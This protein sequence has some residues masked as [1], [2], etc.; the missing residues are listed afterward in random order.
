[1]GARKLALISLPP[2]GCMPFERLL[3]PSGTASSCVSSINREARGFNR[4]LLALSIRMQKRLSDARIVYLDIYAI[5]MDA[6]TNPAKYGIYDAKHGTNPAK[7]G[8]YDAKHGTNPAKYRIYESC[9]NTVQILRDPGC[10]DDKRLS[11]D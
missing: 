5:S 8:I 11:F 2:I 6:I 10:D 3:S 7:H 1:M 4:E 9:E